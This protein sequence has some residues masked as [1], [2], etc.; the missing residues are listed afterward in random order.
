MKLVRAPLVHKLIAIALGA[1]F[2]YASVDKI[3]KP[4]DFARIIYHYQMIGPS[5]ALGPFWPNLLAITLPWIEALVGLALVTGF[6][7]REAALVAGGLLVV[8]VAAVGS[9]LA[10]G[11]D[12]ENCGCFS[13]S[14]EG[15]AAGLKLIVGDLLLLAG[16]AILVF[17]KPRQPEAVPAAAQQVSAS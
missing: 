10:R 11:I 15:R 7:R 9:A 3:L 1:V 8:F 14:G 17:V 16:A 12:L 2:L 13:V 6:W 4:G 5:Q